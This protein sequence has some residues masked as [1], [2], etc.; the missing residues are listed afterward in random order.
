MPGPNPAAL[1]ALVLLPFLC[2]ESHSESAPWQP[3]PGD[4]KKSPVRVRIVKQGIEHQRTYDGNAFGISA[5]HRF[6]IERGNEQEVWTRFLARDDL[7]QFH[8]FDVD[9]D[10]K[11]END[12]VACHPFSL[13]APMTP[14]APFYDTTIGS[15]RFYG[16]AAIFQANAKESGFSEDGMNDCEEGPPYQPRR[17]W[18]FFHETYEIF[19]PFR[20]Y[21]VILW[22]KQ[23]FMNGGAT[24]RVSFD[25]ESELAYLVMRYYMGIEGFRFVVR[26]G[27]KFYISERVSQGSGKPLGNPGGIAHVI[28]PAAERW[29]EYNPRAPYRI[30]FDPAKAAFEKRVFDDVTAVGW[31]MFKD[32]L[33]SGY[34]GH[35]WYAFEADAVVDRPVRPSESIAMTR[36]EAAG[37]PPFYIATCETPYE[38]WRKIHKLGRSNAFARSP[39]GAN[40]Q[41]RGAMGSMDYPDG[42]GK[43]LEH[44]GEEP[45]T[46]VTIPDVLAWCNQLSAAES[47]TPCYYEDPEFKVVFREVVQSPMYVPK[48]V[49]PKVY[50][51]WAAD[52]YR[53]PTPAEWAAAA[54]GTSTPALKASAKT[55]PV[56][57]AAP[58]RNGLRSM[59]G[60]AWELTWNFGDAFDLQQC[61]KA[62]AMGGS[63]LSPS[64]P[65][66]VSASP[67]GDTPFNGRFDIGFRLLRRDAAQ[68]KPSSAMDGV[69]PALPTW[70]IAKDARSKP[71]PERQ[72]RAPLS[73]PLIPVKA[74]PGTGTALGV[75]EVTFAAWKP[76]YDWAT[77]HGYLFTN[78][79]EMGSMAYWGFGKDWTPGSHG[80]DEPVTG[81]TSYDMMVWTNALSE[82]EG[83]SPVYFQDQ[84]FSKV[85]KA[86]FQY[87]PLQLLL[88][89]GDALMVSGVLARRRESAFENYFLK[90]DADGYRLPEMAEFKAAIAC[91]EKTKFPWGDEPKGVFGNAWTADSSGFR[92]H[93]VGTCKPN[94]WGFS[95]L[96]GNASEITHGA[97]DVKV[98]ATLGYLTRT[99]AS[100][101][102]VLD[103]L[104][105]RMLAA[106][107]AMGL[108][109]PDVGFR[110]A[111]P[112]AK[113]AALQGSSLLNLVGTAVE[114]PFALLGSTQAHAEEPAGNK[115]HDKKRRAESPGP[116]PAATDP[117]PF[118][119]LQGC[120]HRAN[121]RR[122]GF[123]RTSGL[124]TFNKIKWKC[125]T[126]GPVRS[127]PVVVKDVVYVGSNDGFFY[128]VDAK[129]GAM[130]W[131]CKTGGT[132]S[133][134]AALVTGTVYFASEDGS[135]YAVRAEDGSEVWKADLG[136][137]TAGSPALVHGVVYIGSSRTGSDTAGMSARPILGFDS[138][139]GKQVWVSK[140]GGPQ[141]Y[142]AIATDGA[143]LYA[144]LNGSTY[145]AFDIASGAQAWSVNGGHQNRQFMS[146]TVVDGTVF[147]P[148]AMRGAVMATDHAGKKLW[149][150]SM[151]DG[152]L[153]IELNQGGKFGY[154]CFTDLAVANGLVL[155]GCNDGKLYAFDAANGAKK[156]TFA[157][158]GKVQSS[159]SIAGS[160]VFFGSWDGNLYALD[161]QSGSLRWKC[162]LGTRVISSPWP[163]DGVV[164]VGCDDGFIYAVE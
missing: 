88:G 83:K 116:Q 20:M 121:L 27:E 120:V 63:F 54:A 33:I 22:Q 142:A 12:V 156:W 47:K 101:M 17:N 39:R 140:E 75:T 50:V 19:S 70:S 134:S 72:L 145:G 148:T 46:N 146:M 110:I 102:D 87:Q 143:R 34:L 115:L 109:Y 84:G 16:G 13:E 74:I 32:N 65:L 98:D 49:L 53:L 164:Y 7:K 69:N 154:E 160:L 23:D 103:G 144:G 126:G 129:T 29:A 137:K 80:P 3:P 44:S 85:V 56:D 58:D 151:L 89:E 4:G 130:K 94:K 78:G 159:P 105:A 38:L 40:F 161:L 10:G 138:A 149:F 66:S 162:T 117:G 79:G 132:N 124:A 45:V 67:Y 106:P 14:V 152:Q 2:T 26:N 139:T 133:G 18:T 24:N 73:Y 141:G 43:Y 90:R 8:D 157:T 15:Q 41:S 93:P 128:A 131:K 36:I 51:N 112:A 5:Y 95:D 30:D 107:T 123:F 60:N 42:S 31:Y 61:E 163:G 99:G 37:V 71:I 82:L 114:F 1:L 108:A 86:A 150:S 9:G 122:D 136:S 155:A 55:A 118:D 76:V 57:E 59:F 147:I 153:D 25:E 11:V 28:R 127:S 119:D 113:T 92:T 91:G 111:C 52:G 97:S 135:T 21:M 62:F 125:Q 6:R 35:K 81:I 64:E 96:I 158:G 48:R 104:D 68:P 100:F 77:A